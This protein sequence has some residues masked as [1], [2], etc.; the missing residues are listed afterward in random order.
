MRYSQIERE[1]LAVTYACERNRLYLHGKQFTIVNDNKALINILN[2]PKSK[3]PLRIERML[4][5]LQGY[6]FQTKYVQSA[7]NISDFLSRHP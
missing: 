1:C 3:P 2:N 7:K 5:R 4:L 6:N